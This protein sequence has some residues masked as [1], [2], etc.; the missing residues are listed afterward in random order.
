MPTGPPTCSVA[1][2]PRTSS[3]AE[4]SRQVASA[5]PPIRP[6]A[7]GLAIRQPRPRVPSP[8]RPGLPRLP[9]A[10]GG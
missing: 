8:L 3:A 6:R 10:P 2:P 4:A 1:S 7:S 9:G 5:S